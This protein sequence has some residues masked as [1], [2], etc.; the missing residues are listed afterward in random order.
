M[1][2]KKEITKSCFHPQPKAEGHRYHFKL[3]STCV[4]ATGQ[5]IQ[6][7]LLFSYSHICPF[8]HGILGWYPPT[9]QHI[10]QFRIKDGTSQA[11]PVSPELLY[12]AQCYLLNSKAVP[13]VVLTDSREQ[14]RRRGNLTLPSPI[15]WACLVRFL[16]RKN[17]TTTSGCHVIYKHRVSGSPQLSSLGQQDAHTQPQSPSVLLT[18]PEPTQPIGLCTKGKGGCGFKTLPEEKTLM[19]PAQSPTSPFYLSKGLSHHT[20]QASAIHFNSHF[21]LRGSNLHQG[22]CLIHQA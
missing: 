6:L 1:T 21:Y 14:D 19:E 17:I 5:N 2:E 16:Q 3:C 9:C 10:K 4:S 13:A 8:Q 20:P 15:S 11:L 12:I 22:Q 7:L 18:V